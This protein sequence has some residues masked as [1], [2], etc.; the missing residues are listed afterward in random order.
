M[1]LT[2]P[3][4]SAENQF[5]QILEGYFVSVYDE[6]S[7]PSH[8]IDHHRRV[9][10]FAKELLSLNNK[11]DPVMDSQLPNSLIIACY[12]HD[13]GMSVDPG[14]R[15]G[16]H[17]MEL[18]NRF[19]HEHE[20]D[21]NDFP[22]LLKAIREHDNKEYGQLSTESD[23]SSILS[24]ADD[25]DAFGFTGIY[26]YLEIYCIRGYEL[27][28]IGQRIRENAAKRFAYFEKC[29]GSA[30]I[31]TKAQR[32]RY[33][34]LDSYFREYNKELKSQKYKILH[35]SGHLQVIELISEAI[36]LRKDLYEFISETNSERDPV[37][38]W[39]F[40]ELKNESHYLTS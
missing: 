11:R 18:C 13:I 38:K 16:S 28:T 31:F 15:H 10:N 24:V 3:I 26:R 4:I 37:V 23:L 40:D 39:F 30:E 27:E 8:G 14:P 17:S 33:L 7:L 32:K 25:L 36:R 6:K 9:W 29:F 1:D 22:G 19:L 35:K 12:L 20:W 21:E 5:K 2:G 34:I